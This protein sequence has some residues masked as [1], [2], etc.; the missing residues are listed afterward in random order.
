MISP[1]RLL[2]AL[3]DRWPLF[4]RHPKNPRNLCDFNKSSLLSPI[5]SEDQENTPSK[6]WKQAQRAWRE[7]AV[8]TAWC[9]V[10][11]HFR[12]RK[13]PLLFLEVNQVSQ[14]V[15]KIETQWPAW[16]TRLLKRVEQD[17]R[18]G[19]PIYAETGPPLG[20]TFDWQ[21]LS[22]G[23]NNDKLYLV[24]PHRFGFV[25]RLA[26][27]AHY[28][29]P[30]LE[31]LAEVLTG[32]TTL[33]A[34]PSPMNVARSS[35]LVVIYRL[36]ALLWG[37]TFVRALADDQN[38]MRDRL[39]DLIWRIIL[40]DVAYLSRN[41]GAA[42]SNNHLLADRFILWFIAALLPELAA[43]RD[44]KSAE[45]A[46]TAELV[47]QTYDDG[48]YFE[49]SLHYQ[50]LGCEMALAYFLL[51]RRNSWPLSTGIEERIKAML[52]FQTSLVGAHLVVPAFGDTT[53]DPLFPLGVS[54][55]WQS[56]FLHEVFRSLF[57][58]E[59]QSAGLADPSREAAFWW[60]AGDLAPLE[61]IEP[62]RRATYNAFP[63]AGLY[64]FVDQALDAHL[65]LRTGVKKGLAHF[66]G[67]SHND[68]LSLYLT[69]DGQSFLASP[70][71]FTYRFNRAAMQ[72]GKASFRHC[73]TSQASR[74]AP[75][76]EGLEPYDP[77][78]GDFRSWQL[79]CYS[80]DREQVSRAARL[81]WLEAVLKGPSDYSG[82][83]RG[84][85]HVVGR[86]WVLYDFFPQRSG[87]GGD[88][89]S[90]N[91]AFQFAPPVTVV[92]HD[93]YRTI[94][95]HSKGGAL[96]LLARGKFS[97]SSLAKGEQI[98]LRGWVSTSYGHMEPA[99]NLRFTLSPGAVDAAFVLLPYMTDSESI[100]LESRLL[101]GGN[102]ALRLCNGEEE[103]ILLVNRSFSQE[104]M[105]AWSVHFKGALL[106][107]HRAATGDWSIRGLSLETFALEGVHYY[108]APQGKV[109]GGLEGLWSDGKFRIVRAGR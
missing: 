90:P 8:E 2:G 56:G 70:G 64:S 43:G 99:A 76:L 79:R 24:R 100:N 44:A 38:A 42:V 91:I 20:P 85:V 75:F 14:L 10:L 6:A 68:L 73:L 58:P 107:F 19:L 69:L 101:G 25:P 22:P 104:S 97:E 63:Q 72:R 57:A 82:M 40:S 37:W 46:W 53:E 23:P 3:L 98:P 80:E 93:T 67:H 78:K 11:A 4:G 31:T 88:R 34:S 86:F 84:L 103:H 41:A 102:L 108:S 5:L 18:L 51:M 26:L 49:P 33:A 55:G 96:T 74:S 50:E 1:P 71:T 9:A 47:R 29:A 94:L 28:G 77:L 109:D 48:G 81:A 45:A 13:R 35:T 32:W 92:H 60:L 89:P 83:T 7:D 21:K 12:S 36:L 39:E 17:C 59:L 52:H 54:D 62:T 105:E 61:K 27:A 16:R 15:V 66:G 30:S 65:V 106:Y 87:G 95:R